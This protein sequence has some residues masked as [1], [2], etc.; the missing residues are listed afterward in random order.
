[1]PDD[2]C[3]LPQV[4]FTAV[5]RWVNAQVDLPPQLSHALIGHGSF[6]NGLRN[7]SNSRLHGHD[8]AGHTL[9]F[10]QL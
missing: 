7:R 4:V 2:V 3:C 9:C 8:S 5:R 10:A 6:Q 1:M